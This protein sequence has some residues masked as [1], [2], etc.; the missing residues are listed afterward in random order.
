[1]PGLVIA[2]VQRGR[3]IRQQGG[4]PRFALD[5]RL[6]AKIFAVEIQKI[7][8]EEDQRRGVAAVGRGLDHAEGGDAIG[9]HAA[10]FAVEIGLLGADR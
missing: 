10:Q 2:V 9:A 7:E 1:V 4:K 3:R 5:K 8:Q 6:R